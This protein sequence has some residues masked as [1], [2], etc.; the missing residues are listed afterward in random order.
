GCGDGQQIGYGYRSFLKEPSRVLLW[1][2]TRESLVVLTGP[3][4]D[5]DAMG[6]AVCGGVQAGYVGGSGR[7]RACLWRGAAGRVVG[8]HPGRDDTMGS[9]V[10]GLDDRQQ[11]G[12]IWNQHAHSEAALWTGSADS[13]VNLAPD[14][15]RRSRASRCAHGLQIGWVAK[16]GRGMMLRA[17]L[18]NG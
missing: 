16:E 6:N 13:Y 1:R 11:V 7:Q 15:F 2:G 12:L 10:L 18:W 17:V 9:E 3:D 14:T 4:S 8:L 5:R